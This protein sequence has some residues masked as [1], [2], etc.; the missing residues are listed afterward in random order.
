MWHRGIVLKSEKELALMREAG[1]TN[2]LALAAAIAVVKPGVTTAEIDRAAAEVLRKRGAQPAFKNY[3]GPYPY[4]AVTTVSINDEL[5]HGIPGKRR[6][7]EGDV[8]SVDCGA[9]LEGYV[10]DSALTVGVGETSE[11]ARRLSEATREALFVGIEHM[12]PGAR[13]GDVSAAIQG[14]VEGRGFQVVREYSGHGV[15]RHMH[16]DPQLPNHGRPG[17]GVVLRP[18]M[19]IAIEPMVLAGSPATR[20]LKDQW[21]V[22]SADG[23]LTAHFE[24]TVAVTDR[25]PWVL[26]AVDEGLDLGLDV[27]YNEYFA[28]R[29]GAPAR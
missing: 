1:R 15:G 12:R 8:V 13:A 23:R 14:H 27:S 25:G 22:A 26:T 17:T 9:V 29:M 4:P 5:V 18:G 2:A 6:L 19:T 3:P 7:K 24:H 21:T 11:E 20:V 16:E 10:A 28:G